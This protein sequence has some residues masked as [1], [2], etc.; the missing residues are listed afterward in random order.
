MRCRF[1]LHSVFHSL[2]DLRVGLHLHTNFMTGLADRISGAGW[3]AKE[4]HRTCRRTF[5][6]KR[7]PNILE[8]CSR[9]DKL[10]CFHQTLH[11]RFTIIA[12]NILKCKCRVYM[13]QV[14]L[15]LR[16]ADKLFCV[17]LAPFT[18][19]GLRVGE[20]VFGILCENGFV[21]EE[22]RVVLCCPRGECACEFPVDYSGKV[23]VVIDD[24]V[25]GIEICV[26]KIEFSRFLTNIRGQY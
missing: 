7:N 5:P 13:L 10:A 14:I 19:F 22:F 17:N 6:R 11:R 18:E 4:R 2:R 26:R 9:I 15:H 23:A 12:Q 16:I 24:D 21:A 25:L 8:C 1:R 20:N 3:R